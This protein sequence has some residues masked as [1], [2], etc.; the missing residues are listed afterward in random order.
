M[1]NYGKLWEKLWENYGKV[2]ILPSKLWE[3]QDL[4]SKL[5]EKLRFYHQDNG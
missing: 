4:P 3:N 1:E 2:R 5:W